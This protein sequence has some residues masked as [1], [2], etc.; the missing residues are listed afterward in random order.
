MTSFQHDEEIIA[1]AKKA[2]RAFEG[3]PEWYT[4]TEG[5]IEPGCMLALR[6]GQGLDCVKVVRLDEYFQPIIFQQAIKKR[7]TPA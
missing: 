1:F 4:F 3:H 5:D 7:E 2:A 6:W